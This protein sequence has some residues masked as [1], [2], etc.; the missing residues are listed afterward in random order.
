ME[1]EFFELPLMAAVEG[2]PSEMQME[3]EKIQGLMQSYAEAGKAPLADADF[4]MDIYDPTDIYANDM[5]A[6]PSMGQRLS[7]ALRGLTLSRRS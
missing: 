2:G 1:H 5:P 7:N 3:R 6:R 4:A